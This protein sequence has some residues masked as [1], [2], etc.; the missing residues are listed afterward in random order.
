MSKVQEAGSIIRIGFALLKCPLLNRAYLVV[1]QFILI[2]SVN[3][4][5]GSYWNVDGHY[6]TWNCPELSRYGV[7]LYLLHNA[8]FKKTEHPS[9][10]SHNDY[11]K[12]FT[13]RNYKQQ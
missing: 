7:D 11:N 9:V 3:A 8:D 1:I 4:A 2:L 5:Y 13:P 10:V 12:K 6:I